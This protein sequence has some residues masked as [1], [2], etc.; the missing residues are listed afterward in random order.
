MTGEVGK[1]R[2]RPTGDP[3]LENCYDQS[4]SM[5][6][7]T[8]NPTRNSLCYHAVM[9]FMDFLLGQKTSDV[10]LDPRF[11][12][13]QR[14]REALAQQFQT[15][16]LGGGPTIGEQ[17]VLAAGQRQA[18]EAAARVMSRAAGARGFGR[19]AA[20]GDAQRI[21]AQQEQA[22]AGQAATQAALQRQQGI[23]SARAGL[24]GTIAQQEQAAIMEEEER[25]RRARGGFLSPIL[26]AGGGLL[27]GLTGGQ[28][29]AI[30]GA[31]AGGV[32][33]SG[34]AQAAGR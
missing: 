27:G 20:R 29:G 23:Q 4:M 3:G 33:G 12:E 25:K 5:A 21:A 9:G 18:D 8:R 26:A 16:A 24:A 6:A 10:E 7:A 14:R 32:L 28:Q 22:I 2:V 34:L 19:L 13:A 1:V 30:T 17:A 11:A 15:E 31:Q